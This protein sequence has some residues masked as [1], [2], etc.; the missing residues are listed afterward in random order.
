M[1]KNRAN[2]V[3]AQQPHLVPAIVAALML[4]VALAQW[5]YGYYQILRWVVCATAVFVVWC[6]YSWNKYWAIWFFALVAVLFNPLVPVHLSRQVWR[7][8]DIVSALAF[9][10][11]IVALSKPPIGNGKKAQT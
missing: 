3:L 5:P 6:S 7:P 1:S 4:L 9:L 11:S 8:I 10:V 2:K